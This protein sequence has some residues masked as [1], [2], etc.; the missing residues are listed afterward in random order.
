MLVDALLQHEVE[1]QVN[2]MVEKVR[3]LEIKQEVVEA[4]KGLAEVAKKVVEVAKGVAEV[5]KEVVEMAK[6]VIRVVKE[7]VETICREAVVGMAWEDFK[8]LLREECCPNNEMQ[9]LETEFWCH[10]MVGAGHAAYTDRFHELSRREPVVGGWD[11]NVRNDNKRSMIGR[12]F[13]TITNPVRKEYT[14][15]TPKCSNWNYQHPPEA[16]CRLCINCNRFGHIA[17][18]C[19]VGPRVV[20]SLNARNP[21]TARGEYFECGGTN[22][23]KAACPQVKPSPKTRRKPSKS[24]DGYRGRIGS[25]KQWQPGTWKIFCDGSRGSSPGPEHCDGHGSFDV[26]IGMDWLSWHK[27]EI[28]CHEKFLGHVINGE[29][30]HVDPNKIEAVKNWEAPRTP[31]EVRSFLGLAGYYRRFIENFSKI[32]KSLTILTQKSKMFDWGKEQELAFQT[33][34]DKLCNAPVLSL[35]DRP[36]DFVVYCDVSCLGLGCVLMQRGKLFSDYDCEIRYHPGKANVVT[37]ELSRKEM[38]KPKR[39][40]SDDKRRSN[41][42]L[43]NLN[44]IWVPLMGEVR[45]LIMDEAYKSKY[46]VHPGADKMYV[47]LRD[48]YWWLGVKKDIAMAYVMDFGGSWDVHLPLVEFSYNNSY[49]LKVKLAP[50]F[51]GPFEITERIDPVAYRLGLTEELNGVPGHVFSVEHQEIVK[52]TQTLHVPLGEISVDAKLDCGRA[53]VGSL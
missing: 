5:A 50:R 13:D 19:R 25:W 10:V 31:S 44:R 43:Y 1:G 47:D 24:S 45:T 48:M 6:K 52:L 51:V 30:I 49:I 37:D 4:A 26:I 28:L 33:L 36:E 20:N 32:A 21:T 7:V 38:I 3:G 22:H 40:R 27:A 41:G 12:A 29:G 34:K 14:G 8:V 15:T 16:P 42:A 53:F 9:K 18:D 23:Y 39:G 2:R 46:S 17:K 35:L 11:G